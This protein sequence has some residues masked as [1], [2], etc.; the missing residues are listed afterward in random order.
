MRSKER[1]EERTHEEEE[2]EKM[3]SLVKMTLTTSRVN[4]II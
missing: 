2:R 3:E 4:L 1:G